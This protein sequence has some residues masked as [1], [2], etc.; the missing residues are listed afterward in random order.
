MVK[1]FVNGARV[2]A[3]TQINVA[4]AKNLLHRFTLLD[5]HEPKYKILKCRFVEKRFLSNNSLSVYSRSYVAS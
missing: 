4:I 1:E 2:L 3:S 5:L